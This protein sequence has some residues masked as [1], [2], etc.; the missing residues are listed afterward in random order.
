MVTEAWYY[1]TYG[2]NGLCRPQKRYRQRGKPRQLRRNQLCLGGSML[3][4]PVRKE[5]GRVGCADAAPKPAYL[6][7]QGKV[8]AVCAETCMHGS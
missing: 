6:S 5:K 8:R 2:C 3:A 4:E 7:I 1:S